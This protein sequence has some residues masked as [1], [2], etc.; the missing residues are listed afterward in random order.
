M[1]GEDLIY[2]TE[3]QIGAMLLHADDVLEAMDMNWMKYDSDGCFIFRKHSDMS[4]ASAEMT[5]NL[6]DMKSVTFLQELYRREEY[7]IDRIR[8]TDARD[9]LELLPPEMPKKAAGIFRHG[10]E[11]GIYRVADSVTDE[12]LYELFAMKVREMMLLYA[13]GRMKER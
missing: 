5:E 6:R 1:T 7:D 4:K 10:T 3:K 12:Y 8:G 13:A 9:I 2:I 11:S